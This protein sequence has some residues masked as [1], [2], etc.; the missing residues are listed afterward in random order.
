[1]DLISERMN[2]YSDETCRCWPLKS[3]SCTNKR[4]HHIPCHL[5]DI[6]LRNVSPRTRTTPPISPFRQL[7][8]LPSTCHTT[9]TLKG[10]YITLIINPHF[11]N[12]GF[13]KTRLK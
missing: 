4:T 11:L 3:F 6:P 1:M 2:D 7:L 8:D 13:L 12:R 5:L 10:R 9:Q